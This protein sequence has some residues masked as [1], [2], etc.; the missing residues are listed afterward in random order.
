MA[1]PIKLTASVIETAPGVFLTCYGCEGEDAAYCRAMSLTVLLLISEL[2]QE[3]FDEVA[4][5]LDSI[6]CPGRT[7]SD[8]DKAHWGY[9]CVAIWIDPPVAMPGF[10]CFTNDIYPE[11]DVGGDPPQFT[12]AQL[13]IILNH[14]RSF[15]SEIAVHGKR[16]LSG[17]KFDVVFE[18]A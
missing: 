5:L 9:N 8:G 11:L 15:T 18:E 12:H 17:K 14:W 13:A 1:P 2:D 16:A 4:Q 10:A 3:L 7:A 6:D